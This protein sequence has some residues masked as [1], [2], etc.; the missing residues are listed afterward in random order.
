M[1]RDPYCQSLR[2]RPLQE[3]SSDKGAQHGRRS[4]A[5]VSMDG[6][7][8]PKL[9]SLEAGA[10]GHGPQGDEVPTC[11]QLQ[12][13]QSPP[14]LPCRPALLSDPSAS[15]CSHS[16]QTGLLPASRGGGSPLHP[17]LGGPAPSS[18]LRRSTDLQL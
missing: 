7:G 15:P 11:H 9:L 4:A 14:L 13:T 8:W 12:G 6:T 17:S 3:G 5:G 10:A 2:S 18:P 16:G 1:H